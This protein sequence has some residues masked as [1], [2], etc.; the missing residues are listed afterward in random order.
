MALTTPSTL[1]RREY[2]YLIDEDTVDQIRRYI[3][4]ICTVDP[5]AERT[6]GRYLTDTLYLDTPQLHCYWATVDDA[7]DRYKLRMRG[8]PSLG[9]GPVFFEVKRRISESVRKTRGWFNGP[10]QQVLLDGTPELLATIDP[11]QRP[12]ID[13]FICHYHRSPMLPRCLVRYEREPYMSLID[14]Y[15]RVTFDRHVTYQAASELSLIGDTDHWTPIDDAASQRG[16]APSS[17]SVLL[18]LKFTSVVPSWMRSMIQTL[19][20]QRLAFCKYTRAVDS[21]RFVPGRRIPRAGMF[22]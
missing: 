20:V 2:K 17:S 16:M 4:G 8:Y 1:Q 9:E 22:G 19:G 15:A 14:E 5:Y 12:A 11:R 21:M 3:A 18:E 10:W 13:N 6:G 7:G